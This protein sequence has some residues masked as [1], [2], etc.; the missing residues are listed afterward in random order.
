MS[1]D[2]NSHTSLPKQLSSDSLPL[3]TTMVPNMSAAATIGAQQLTPPLTSQTAGGSSG[4]SSPSIQL[5]QDKGE[6]K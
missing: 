1:R 2:D 3:K 4:N 5:T 6:K